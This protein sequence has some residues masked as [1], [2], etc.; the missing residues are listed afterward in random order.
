M[1]GQFST[2]IQGRNPNVSLTASYRIGPNALGSIFDFIKQKAAPGDGAA[3]FNIRDCDYGI[4]VM[5]FTISPCAF[6][7][8]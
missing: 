1:K 4:A 2:D 8:P 7:T 3:F 5:R 6:R